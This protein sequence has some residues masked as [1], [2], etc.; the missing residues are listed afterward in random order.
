M[1]IMLKRPLLDRMLVGF[2]TT[3]E[4]QGRIQDF[5]LGDALKIIA[6]SGTRHE[7]FWGISCEKSRFYANKNI[8]YPI[9]GGARRVGP[10]DPP[11]QSVPVT[12]DVVSSNL[13][14]DEIC[15]TL[16]AKVC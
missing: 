6:P 4:I 15:T 1:K 3:Y 9:L 13:D 5:K 14:Q 16:C 2:T 7:N 12:T 8:F 10:L 11:L